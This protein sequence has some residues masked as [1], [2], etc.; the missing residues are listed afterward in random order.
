MLKNKELGLAIKAAL[1]QNNFS[2]AEAARK[3]N[4]K[5]PSITGWIQTGRISK[6]NFEVL[7]NWCVKTPLSH[8]GLDNNESRPITNKLDQLDIDLLNSFNKLKTERQKIEII[9]YVQ[10]KVS[11]QK[12][13]QN[14]SISTK[15]KKA[16]I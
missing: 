14:L 7:K 1:E 10:G 8:W 6:E 12:N 16:A 4:L 2:Q 11:E 9:G 5:P 13:M 3:F 15:T